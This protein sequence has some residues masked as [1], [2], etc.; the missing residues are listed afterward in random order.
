MYNKTK[1]VISVVAASLIIFSCG[2]SD[3]TDTGTK[4]KTTTQDSKNPTGQTEGSQN[5]QT[6]STDKKDSV[7]KSGKLEVKW[8]FRPLK[9]GLYDTPMTDVYLTVNGKS[10]FVSKIYYSFSETLRSG[11]KDYVQ[12]SAIQ[13][14]PAM[15]AQH[16]R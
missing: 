12:M 5:Q 2:K 3:K 6:G 10:Q 16:Q 11:Y 15:L 4:E 13:Q 7:S 14:K 8:D 9:P 1:F